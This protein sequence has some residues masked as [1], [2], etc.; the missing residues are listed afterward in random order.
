MSAVITE[1]GNG[2]NSLFWVDK[3]IDGKSIRE[4]APG[5]CSMVK[6]RGA[7][8]R[9]VM[10][11]LSDNKWMDD[12]QGDMSAEV[13]MEFLSLCVRLEEVDLH[14]D[15]P[16]KHIWKLSATGVYTAKSA[17]EALFQGATHFRPYERIWK[18]WAPPKCRFFM[19]LVAHRRCWTAD[20]LA[21]RGLPHPEVCLLCDQEEEDIHHL[22]IGCVFARQV[23]F[24]LLQYV[25][26]ES[27]A[28][29]SAETSFDDWWEHAEGRVAGD[30]RAGLNSLVIL[31][32]WTIWRHRND[33]VFNGGSPSITT[34]LSLAKDEASMWGMAGAK[35]LSRLV[36]MAGDG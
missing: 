14:H 29:H 28:P 27:L 30:A 23:W 20:R 12:I 17:Y 21:R 25:G 8:K 18:S 11:A 4:L 26:L 3:W 36:V 31:G 22:L 33:C 6:R 24:H 16:D 5:L 13:V 34:V 2:E 1:V 19:W 35:G 9:S 10:D 32:A 7:Q 15:H